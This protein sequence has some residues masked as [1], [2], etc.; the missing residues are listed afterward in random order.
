MKQLIKCIKNGVFSIK[1]T[2]KQLSN[3]AFMVVIIFLVVACSGKIPNGTYI[4]D[5]CYGD[6]ASFTFSKKKIIADDTYNCTT[7]YDGEYAYSLKD[8]FFILYDE[9]GNS[10]DVKYNLD[11]KRLTV[12]DMYSP[13]TMNKGTVF[14]KTKSGGGKSKK[15]NGTYVGNNTGGSE[16]SMTFS[17][18]KYKLDF[19]YGG[20][21]KLVEG[22]YELLERYKEKDISKGVIIL[23]NPNGKTQQKYVL[24]GDKLTIDEEVLTKCSSGKSNKKDY[25]KTSKK[26]VKNIETDVYVAGS[27]GA[28]I[29]T[30]W[31]NGVA[32]NL[33]DGKCH[34]W[35]SSVFVSGNDVYVAGSKCYQA[36]L[37]KNGNEQYL[38][39]GMFASSV[40]VLGNDEYVTGGDGRIA[41]LWRNGIKHNLTD[42]IH[43]AKANS[44]YVSGNSVYVAGTEN[45][46]LECYTEEGS[47]KIY[48][49]K[50]WINGLA[51]NLTDGTRM[52]E[53]LSIY[54]SGKDV[55]VAGYEQNEK[56]ISIAKI[57]KN[58]VVQNLTDGRDFAVTK[59]IFVS[60]NDVYAL[61]CGGGE[62]KSSIYAH[63]CNGDYVLAGTSGAIL[64]KNNLKEQYFIL[65]SANSVFVFDRYVYVVGQTKNGATIWISGILMNLPSITGHANVNSVF[66]VERK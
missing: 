47:H 14:T 25:K 59:S 26:I 37:W 29:A 16:T 30:I 50:V 54:V 49:A 1:N 32:Q 53:A 10:K 21:R 60:N 15:L 64:F 51:Q 27:D 19:S 18:N 20:E 36:V 28:S 12:Y 7:V 23:N 4:S 9:S 22:T 66:V 2:I 42:G 3:I 17:G 33:T 40:F 45:S 62:S 65:N 58:G 61:V 56:G 41:I 44:I 34:A 13:Q 5:N 52:A 35:A 63:N 38:E 6:E 48:V 39:K 31:K 8:G 11:G 24:D 43:E 55:F 46:G 57:W